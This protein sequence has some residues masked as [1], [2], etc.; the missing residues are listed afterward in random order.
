M[1]VLGQP[2]C[3]GATRRANCAFDSGPLR[4][5]SPEGTEIIVIVFCIPASIYRCNHRCSASVSL[6]RSLSRERGKRP[7]MESVHSVEEGVVEAVVESTR[8]DQLATTLHA[9]ALQGEVCMR[10]RGC[11]MSY[12]TSWQWQINTLSRAHT[13]KHR[14]CARGLRGVYPSP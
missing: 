2:S 3:C 5:R 9:V 12:W 13:G 11:F 6:R 7:V 10:M 8:T 1:N 14:R 4:C